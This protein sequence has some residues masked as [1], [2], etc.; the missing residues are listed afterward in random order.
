MTSQLSIQI[1]SCPLTALCCR[2]TRITI[3]K[4][5]LHSRGAS[6]PA[7]SRVAVTPHWCLVSRVS[8][9]LEDTLPLSTA[10]AKNASPLSIPTDCVL[11]LS[12]SLCGHLRVLRSSPRTLTHPPPRYGPRLSLR[13]HPIA[14]RPLRLVLRAH[15]EEPQARSTSSQKAAHV[16]R[17]QCRDQYQRWV[18][19]DSAHR[20]RRGRRPPDP[21]GWQ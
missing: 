14:R 1:G 16:G 19:I 9:V 13:A 6:A 20:L 11:S 7:P 3:T 21:R 15:S 12:L 2:V 4:S 18:R 10:Q 8:C 5:S 17:H